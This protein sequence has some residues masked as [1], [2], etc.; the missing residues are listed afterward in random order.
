MSHQFLDGRRIQID[1]KREGGQ[2]WDGIQAENNQLIFNQLRP[3]HSGW[4]MCTGDDGYGN[5]ATDRFRL[6]VVAKPCFN[7][8][9]PNEIDLFVG[10]RLSIDCSANGQGRL[11]Y[12]IYKDGRL[13]SRD[14]PMLVVNE[15]TQQDAGI[16]RCEASNEAGSVDRE[17][18][19][20]VHRPV[21]SIGIE[22]RE[23]IAGQPC[24]LRCSVDG[25]PQGTQ[26]TDYRWYRGDRLVHTGDSTF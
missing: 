23:P 11:V 21:V 18:R 3:S 25:L 15:V 7:R 1:L 8:D 19:V 5:R 22:P 4:Y 16:Y 10:E 26:V 2:G 14:R 24:T 6:D 17:I 20:T 12:V 9:G 13:H